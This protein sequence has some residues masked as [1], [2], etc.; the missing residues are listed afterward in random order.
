MDAERF[1]E[2]VVDTARRY[3]LRPSLVAGVIHVESH[4]DPQA[5]SPAGAVGLMQ[6]MPGEKIPGRPLAQAL[7]D[8]A[9]NIDWG[10]RILRDG[11]TR[12]GTTAGML[13]AYYGAVDDQGRPT[14]A[15]DGSGVTG[16]EYVWRVEQAAMLY[17]GWDL[18]ADPDF[19]Q[20]APLSGAWREAAINL[21]GVA[22]DA[23]AT[24]RRLRD[25]LKQIG[26][27]AWQGVDLWGSR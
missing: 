19:R 27:L 20:Y 8:P 14:D 15:D 5:I 13:A 4:W 25:Q 3:G 11:W 9:T 1:R 16:W 10:C 22:D 6:V 18:T 24:G 17:W 2:L 12:Y 21:K 7:L 23:L 26:S